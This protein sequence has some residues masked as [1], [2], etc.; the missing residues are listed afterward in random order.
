MMGQ[1]AFYI[2]LTVCRPYGFC[3]GPAGKKKGKN[4]N[5]RQ[6][7]LWLLNIAKERL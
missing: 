1:E 3:S 4:E 5:L 6:I 2:L 7:F